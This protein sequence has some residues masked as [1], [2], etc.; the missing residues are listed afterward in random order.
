[1]RRA[2]RSVT[3]NISEGYGG[4][5]YSE[6]AQFCRT[7]RGSAY[8]LLDQPIDSLDIGYIENRHMKN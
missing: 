4:F 8:E 3:H 5:H 1:M 7:S 2:S 6:N